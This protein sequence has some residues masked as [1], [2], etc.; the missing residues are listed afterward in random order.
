MYNIV[1]KRRM[2]AVKDVLT[3]SV[4]GELSPEL[5]EGTKPRKATPGKGSE[6]EQEDCLIIDETLREVEFKL[7]KCCN[8]IFGDSVFGFVTISSGITIHRS[9]CPNA[10]R[11]REQYPYR[12]LSA[13]WRQTGRSGAFRAMIKVQGEDIPGLAGRIT[14]LISQELKLNIRSLS[15]GVQ[16]GSFEGSFSIEVQGAQAVDMVIHKLKKIRGLTRAYRL[17]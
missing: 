12:V 6:R 13:K 8:P 11:L 7:A 5:P 16:N 15:F 14:D 10:K 2:A 9:D 1:D 17:N 3:R 4:S